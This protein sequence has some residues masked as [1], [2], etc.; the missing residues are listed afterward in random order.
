MKHRQAPLKHSR[1]LVNISKDSFNTM[2]EGRRT[3][4]ELLNLCI[5]RSVNF[6]DCNQIVR[7]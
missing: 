7:Q 2:R 1:M 4:S 6:Y 3:T 5:Q